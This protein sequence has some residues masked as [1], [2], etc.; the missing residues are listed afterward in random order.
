MGKYHYT[1]QND[2]RDLKIVSDYTGMSFKELEKLS[3]FDLWYLLSEA[4]IYNCE[5]TEKGREYLENAW[6][7]EQTRPDRKRLRRWKR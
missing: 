7:L 2:T 5:Q 4:V 6:I 1:Y 3:C